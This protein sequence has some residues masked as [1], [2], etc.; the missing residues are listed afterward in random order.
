MAGHVHYPN[1]HSHQA[2]PQGLSV[3]YEETDYWLQDLLA[4]IHDPQLSEEAS[5]LVHLRYIN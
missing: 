5:F 1:L 2:L 4:C 3:S